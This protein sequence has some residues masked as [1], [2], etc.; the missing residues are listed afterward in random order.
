MTNYKEYAFV[1]DAEGKQLSPT[2]IQKAW[3]KIRH[4]L[5]CLVSKYPMVIKLNKTID[6]NDICKDEIRCGIDDGASHVG[7][8]LVQKCQ[9]KNKVL[10]KGTVEHRKDVKKKMSIRREHRNYRRYHKRYRKERYNNRVSSRRKDRIPPSILQRRQAIVGIVCQLRK[11]LSFQTFY[12]EDV[13][14]D[15]R[16][17]TDGYKPYSWQYQ[18]TNRLDS[19]LRTSIL[20]RDGNRCMECGKTDKMLQIHHIIPRRLNGPSSMSNLITLCRDCHH[21]TQGYE[22]LFIEHYS[23]MINSSTINNTKYAQYSMIGK[24]WLRNKLGEFGTLH[25]TTGCDTAN[26]RIDWNIEKTHSNDAICITD[27]KPDTVNIKE[28]CIKPLRKKT[29]ACKVSILGFSHRDLIEYRPRTGLRVIGYI[30]SLYPNNNQLNFT[31]NKKV[32]KRVSMR[33][34]KLLYKFNRFRWIENMI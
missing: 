11:W 8:S 5:A 16:A 34:C 12:L 31:S 32:Y 17:L 7:I 10:F 28:W 2:K 3:Y 20:I 14:I 30:T 24:T 25:I 27:L 33:S 23:K 13:S 18:K 21:K 1:L 4:G 15:V 9:T 6:S 22:E 19:N 26:K 29:K